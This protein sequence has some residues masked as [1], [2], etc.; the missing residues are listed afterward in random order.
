MNYLPK[1]YVS[2][3]YKEKYFEKDTWEKSVKSL[4]FT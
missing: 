2:R 1:E 4:A 3:V